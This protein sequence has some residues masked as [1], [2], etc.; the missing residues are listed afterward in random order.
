MPINLK[1]KNIFFLYLFLFIFIHLPKIT[2]FINEKPH[3]IRALFQ[4]LNSK[5]K[6]K[7][8]NQIIQIVN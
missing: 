1:N 5:K 6:K 3:K 2:G 8:F 4:Q 7:S